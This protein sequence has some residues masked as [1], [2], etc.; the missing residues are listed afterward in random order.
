MF[1]TL[2]NERIERSATSFDI[3]SMQKKQLLLQD[4][5]CYVVSN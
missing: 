1:M 5:V 2:N 4:L 3:T